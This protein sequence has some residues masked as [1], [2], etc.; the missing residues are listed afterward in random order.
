[1]RKRFHT[2]FILGVSLSLGA[3]QAQ[4]PD[5]RMDEMHAFLPAASNSESKWA[6]T[7]IYCDGEFINLVVEVK[8]EYLFSDPSLERSDHLEVWFA[9]PEEDYPEEFNYFEHPNFIFDQW[10]WNQGVLNNYPLFFYSLNPDVPTKL[11]LENFQQL[12]SGTNRLTTSRGNELRSRE[13]FSLGA[14]HFGIV[15]IGFFPDERKP[16]ILNAFEHKAVERALNIRLGA[17]TESIIH[18]VDKHQDG[19]VVNAQIP[20]KSLGFVKLP[21]M[22]SLQFRLD[23]YNRD[24]EMSVSRIAYSTSENLS[25]RPHYFQKVKLSSPLNT[26]FTE[27]PSD[28]LQRLNFYPLGMYTSKGWIPV[29]LYA[30]RTTDLN[31]NINPFITANWLHI[32]PIDYLKSEDLKSPYAYIRIQLPAFNNLMRLWEIWELGGQIIQTEKVLEDEEVKEEPF[33]KVFQFE[34]GDQG[35]LLY[36]KK[37]IDPMGWNDC[38]NCFEE[39]LRIVKIFDNKRKV[40]FTL[41]HGEGEENY[42]QINGMSYSDFHLQDWYWDEENKM[43][44]LRLINKDPEAASKRLKVSWNDNG[45][46]L[47]VIEIR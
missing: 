29:Q 27:I 2:I 23:V 26:N 17:L 45:E 14:A 19:Y 37:Q 5:F 10:S 25:E 40:I 16:V 3:L 28:I 35:I 30:D 11:D 33:N 41:Y 31:G 13:R 20:I 12:W 39:S 8:D 24:K 47:K 18:T 42:L 6:S 22:E 38:L 32:L 15:K 4:D 34:N 43:L 7:Q 44:I 46:K 1:M 9:L 21:E 36:G